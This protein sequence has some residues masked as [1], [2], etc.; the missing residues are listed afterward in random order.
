MKVD[1]SISMEM[2]KALLMRAG[3]IGRE[4]ELGLG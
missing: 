3:L 1:E 2:R 4:Q